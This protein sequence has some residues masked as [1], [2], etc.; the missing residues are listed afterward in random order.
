MAGLLR[1]ELGQPSPAASSPLKVPSPRTVPRATGFAVIDLETTGLFPERHDRIVELGVVVL[2]ADTRQRGEWTTLVNPC[3]D[4]GPTRIHGITASQVADAPTFADVAGDLAERIGDRIIVGHNI[5]F[6]LRFL[7][8]EFGAL[9]SDIGSVEG[10]CTMSLAS[11]YGAGGRSLQA[12]CEEL[13]IEQ[14]GAHQA[15]ADAR[16]TASLL[17][18]CLSRAAQARRPLEL[19]EPL[20]RRALP[21]VPPSGRMLTRDAPPRQPRNTLGTLAARLPTEGLSEGAADGVVASYVE[22]LDRA[23]EDRALTEAEVEGLAATAIALNMSRDTVAEV[24]HEYF[25]GL[26][27]LALADGVL[28]TAE[29]DDLVA[30]ATLL[31][32]PA[33]VAELATYASAPGVVVDRRNEYA[34]RRVCFTGGSLCRIGG[35]PLDRA[36]QQRLAA[37]RGL[38]VEERVTKRLDLL[39]LADP[40]SAS[41]KARLADDLG[42]R[43][44]C[45][46]AFWVSIG[47]DV[48]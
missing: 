17:T 44:V 1:R 36:T 5:R 35:I 14:G 9:G 3:R 42:I 22:L 41:G 40:A 24:H 21:L 45:E 48:D 26:A 4:V 29:R 32:T 31:C 18:C 6:D 38:N 11:R 20:P 2:D 25:A 8:A 15:L 30:I 12:C 37:S 33:A 27:R 10:L 23:L 16:S 13:G 28:T 7:T 43:K 47:V 46:R 19:P 34:G 39:V